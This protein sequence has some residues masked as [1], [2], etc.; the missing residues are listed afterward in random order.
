MNLFKPKTIT[1]EKTVYST[2]PIEVV[3][4]LTKKDF[5]WYNYADL[6]EGER[7]KYYKEAQMILNSGVF[8]NEIHSLNAE[9]AEWSAKKST[10]WENV[11]AMRY[12]I[13]GLMMLQERL[14]SIIDPTIKPK[15]AEHPYEGI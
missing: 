10:C 15:K 1:T 5:D 7:I 4:R 12:E 13:S 14:E 9:F 2:D 8:Q 11:L 6:E 3:N